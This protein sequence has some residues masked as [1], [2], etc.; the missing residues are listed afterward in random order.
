MGL[1]QSYEDWH[2]HPKH[3]HVHWATFISIS[4]IAVFFITNQI[5]LTYNPDFGLGVQTTEAQA[6]PTR[7]IQQADLIHQGSFTLPDTLN[8]VGNIGFGYVQGRLAFNPANNSLFMVG[9]VWDQQVAEISIPALGVVAGVIQTFRDPLEG[10]VALINP[11]DGGRAEGQ[12]GGMWVIGNKLILAVYSYYDGG[13][14]AAFS[15]F[16]RSTNLSTP[17]VQGPFKVGS[18]YAG[19]FAGYFT[20]I[21]TEWQSALGGTLLNGAC[22]HAIASLWS[23]GP[24]IGTVNPADLLA[25]RNPS[26]ATKLIFYPDTNPYTTRI[27]QSDFYNGT[28]EVNGALLVPNT[29]TILFFGKHGTGF[30][31]YISGGGPSAPPNRTQVW[32]FDVNE[33]IAV[34]N[35]TKQ[36]YDVRPYATF[37]MPGIN[38]DL[39]AGA[40]YDPATGRLFITEYAGDGVKARIHV[41]TIAG[42]SSTPNPTPTPTPPPTPPPTPVLTP[43]P[44]QQTPIGKWN[45]NEGSGSTTADSS[46]SN[47]GTL[48]NGATWR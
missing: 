2:N 25:A 9:H 19:D 20:A 4:V 46:G 15:H 41:Y 10:R 27:E 16:V 38:G 22:C 14:T 18:G 48:T 7:L 1:K 29:R 31:T 37:A 17:S 40:A 5:N 21:T 3:P 6:L 44:S 28:T 12:I 33:M 42:T 11:G 39:M 36:T 8:T 26:P 43:T 47:T 34:K 35:G 30:P 45:F 24:A 23:W 32:A 13:G